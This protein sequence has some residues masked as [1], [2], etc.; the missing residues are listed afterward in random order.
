MQALGNTKKA[1]SGLVARVREI[2]R[3]TARQSV[4]S[5]GDVRIAPRDRAPLCA[6]KALQ[7]MNA[8]RRS[9]RLRPAEAARRRPHCRAMRRWRKCFLREASLL[10]Q[11][12]RCRPSCERTA[13]SSCSMSRRID[14]ASRG[15]AQAAI[16]ARHPPARSASSVRSAITAAW[17]TGSLRRYGAAA[18]AIVAGASFDSQAP[19]LRPAG[20]CRP[21][22]SR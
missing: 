18:R 10:E 15:R 5:S 3:A 14:C 8:R 20:L 11:N 22:E 19:A 6:S 17:V 16:D 4:L 13:A 21:A 9:G 12:S 7:P 1:K 2:C